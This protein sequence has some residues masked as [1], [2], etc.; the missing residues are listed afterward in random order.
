MLHSSDNFI[1]ILQKLNSAQRTNAEAGQRSIVNSVAWHLRSSR[2]P[3]NFSGEPVKWSNHSLAGGYYYHD[4]MKCK[5]VASFFLQ[6]IYIV[7]RERPG[8]G[9][10]DARGVSCPRSTQRMRLFPQDTGAGRDLGQEFS[11]YEG[12]WQGRVSSSRSI[13][14]MLSPGGGSISLGDCG[15]DPLA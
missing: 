9:V 2:K 6:F 15:G 13:F 7:P 14:H 4:G 3:Q 11:R 1:K 5:R 10:R 8:N 12:E